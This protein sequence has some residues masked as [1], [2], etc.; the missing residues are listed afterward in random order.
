MI[1][2]RRITKILVKFNHLNFNIPSFFGD[3]NRLAKFLSEAR[4]FPSNKSRV[5][6]LK[7]WLREEKETLVRRLK[8]Q[9]KKNRT[10]LFA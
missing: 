6:C 2:Q 1:S 7:A 8:S 5:S 4:D 9:A 3:L 10:R